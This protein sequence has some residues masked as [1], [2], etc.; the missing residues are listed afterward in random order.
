MLGGILYLIIGKI[1]YR[2]FSSELRHNTI[3]AN[4]ASDVTGIIML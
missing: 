2:A 4:F 1:D 3:S